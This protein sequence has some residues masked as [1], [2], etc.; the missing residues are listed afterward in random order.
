MFMMVG[1]CQ[2]EYLSHV[3]DDRILSTRKFAPFLLQDTI[4]RKVCPMFMMGRYCQQ[5]HLLYVYDWRVLSTG[6]FAPLL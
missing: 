1:Y 5:E 2:Q 4:N 3:Y 6:M